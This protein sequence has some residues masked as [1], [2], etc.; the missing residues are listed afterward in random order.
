MVVRD[1]LRSP[2]HRQYCEDFRNRSCTEPSSVHWLTTSSCDP[3]RKSESTHIW[4][5]CGNFGDE[6]EQ[7][8]GACALNN[9]V[10]LPRP[11]QPPSFASRF[12]A[13]PIADTCT[14]LP[15]G[16]LAPT[17][18]MLLQRSFICSPYLRII[19]GSISLCRALCAGVV[20]LPSPSL[21]EVAT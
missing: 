14:Y 13:A 3:Q 10:T 20:Q 8:N 15:G 9:W 17:T 5:V 4:R 16:C 12:L 19:V 2:F 21:L 6:E 11:S 18:G 1:P 7:S